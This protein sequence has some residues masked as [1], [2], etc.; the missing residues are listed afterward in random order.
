[1][2]LHLS[3]ILLS[4]AACVTDLKW[5]R[6]P[7]PM[8][9]TGLCVGLALNAW[10]GGLRGL[11]WSFLGAGLGLALFL[12]FFALG[13][14]G[15]GDVKLLAAFGALLGPVDLLRV[16]LAA[17]LAGGLLALAAAAWQHRLL[18]TFRAV[19]GLLTFWVSGGLRPA[20]EWSLENPAALKIPYALPLAAGAWLI[21]LARW[22]AP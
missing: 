20:Y 3:V 9:L 12:P 7:N 18:A 8:V 16:A 15:A 14:M 13:G 17:A 1:M 11:G 21:V 22:S 5:R 6:I 4:G 10:A 2:I 19:G